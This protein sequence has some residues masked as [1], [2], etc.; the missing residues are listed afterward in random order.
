MMPPLALAMPS[1]ANW[2]GSKRKAAGRV[3]RKENSRS[4]HDRVLMMRSAVAFSLTAEI[5]P[6]LNCGV[7]GGTRGYF[8]C[9]KVDFDTNPA[10]AIAGGR[11]SGRSCLRHERPDAPQQQACLALYLA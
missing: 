11:S 2:P 6:R 8:Q 4:V 5:G 1:R 3:R 9:D 7:A 10:A